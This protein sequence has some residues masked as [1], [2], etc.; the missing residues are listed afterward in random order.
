MGELR[1]SFGF[2]D[3]HGAIDLFGAQW[4]NRSLSLCQ[5]K[6]DHQEVQLPV[7]HHHR[8]LSCLH[9]LLTST[10]LWSSWTVLGENH[11]HGL[12]NLTLLV[13]VASFPY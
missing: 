12:K 9:S 7:Y 3:F 1:V 11:Q 4:N 5:G 2:E 6:I 10:R 8:N 13:S